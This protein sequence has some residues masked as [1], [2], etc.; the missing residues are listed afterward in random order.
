MSHRWLAIVCL[1]WSGEA[2]MPPM[3]APVPTQRALGLYGGV[4]MGVRRVGPLWAKKGGAKGKARG[5]QMLFVYSHVCMCFV[6]DVGVTCAL[7][8]LA[9]SRPREG[10]CRRSRRWALLH[11]VLAG[12]ASLWTSTTSRQ[13][14]HTTINI[15]NKQTALIQDYHNSSHKGHSHKGQGAHA[16]SHPSTTHPF[17]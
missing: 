15:N 4:G 1:G 9:T 3:S 12:E 14:Q 8:T 11:C 13:L 16:P 2:F 7:Q 5:D 17:N 6:R 10:G